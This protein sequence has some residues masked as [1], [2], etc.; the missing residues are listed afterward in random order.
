MSVRACVLSRLFSLA[1]ALSFAALVMTIAFSC[2]R[3]KIAS[4]PPSPQPPDSVFILARDAKTANQI[5][6]VFN[7]L[8]EPSKYLLTVSEP[9]AAPKARQISAPPG[10]PTPQAY[11]L[12]S[13]YGTAPITSMVLLEEHG[14]VA[15]DLGL[16][17]KI[18][19]ETDDQSGGTTGN[20][21]GGGTT[22]TTGG[23]NSEKGGNIG[24]GA[25]DEIRKA[26]QDV[27]PALYTATY[28]NSDQVTQTLKTKLSRSAPQGQ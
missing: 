6:Q 5:V 24:P 28:F 25:V 9:T 27:N 17:T 2:S 3:P 14:V 7:K 15:S 13:S 26:L 8:A 1:A 16:A 19:N 22:F 4:G 11:Y 12:V 18:G 20:T 10:E 23:T 21:S